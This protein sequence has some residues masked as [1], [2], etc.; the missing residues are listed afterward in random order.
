[1]NANG[2]PVTGPVNLKF[3]FAYTN[4]TASILCT[5]QI[6]GVVLT[7][8]VFHSKLE[9]DC[10][11]STFTSVLNLVPAGEALAIR[12]TDETHTKAYSFQALHAMPAAIMSTMSKQLVQMGAT[13]GQ[14]LAWDGSKWA[15][16]DESGT[17]DG[18]VTSVATG[19][20]LTGG[21]ITTT[22][23]ISIANGGVDTTQLANS[24]VTDAK[25]ATGI[26]R[27]KLAN[28]TANAVIVNSAAGVI[29]EVAQLALTQGGTGAITAAG[30]RTN[31]GLGTAAVADIGFGAGQ[32]M[33]G[34]SVPVCLAHEKLQMNVGPVYWSCAADNDSLDTTKVPLDGSVAMTGALN[35]NAHKILNVTSPTDPGDAANKAYVDAQ[36]GG[37]TS[38]QWL[39]NSG[40]IYYN[41]NNVGI[42]TNN[43]SHQFTTTGDAMVGSGGYP[44]FYLRDTNWWIGLLQSADTSWPDADSFVFNSPTGR[45]FVFQTG[46]AGKVEGTPRMLI[47]ATSGFVGIGTT[48]P[49]ERL[50][51]AGNAA[52]SGKLRL[53]SDNANFVELQAPAALAAGLTFKLPGVAGSAGNALVTDGAGNLSWAAVAT[54]ATSVGGDI[55]GTITNAQINAGAIA[56]AEVAAGAAI[57]Q[58]KI[59]NLTTDLAGKEPTITG[60][61]TDKYWRGDKTWQTLDT[62]VVPENTNLYFTEARV[63]GTDLAGFSATTGAVGAADTVLS[64]F[65]K[66]AGNLAATSAAQ[67]NYVEKDGDTMTGALILN[68]D[69]AVALGA[70]TKQYVDAQVSGTSYWTKTGT[71]VHYDGGNVGI[72]TS[73]PSSKLSVYGDGSYI[74][75]ETVTGLDNAIDGVFKYGYTGDLK[76]GGTGHTNRWHGLDATI[77]AGAGANNKL[78][79]KMFQGGNNNNAGAY[80]MTLQG[81][82][83]V[84]IGTTSPAA[85]LN[86]QGSGILVDNGTVD[87]PNIM[88][89]DATSAKT[90]NMDGYNGSFRIF[91]ETSLNGG[92][93]T[94]RFVMTS[95]GL[96][97]LNTASPGA[98]LDIA[99]TTSGLLIPRLTTAERNAIASPANGLQIF[100]T[101]T[102]EINF[103]HLPST[104]WKALGVAG[105]GVQS[106][107]ASTGLT[108]AGAITNTGT[109]AVDVGTGAGQI[110][111]LDGSAKIPAVDGSLVTNLN[112][113]NLSA[114]VPISK[115]GTGLNAAGTANTILGVNGAGTGLEYK[116]LV[117]NSPL[118]LTNAA[119]SATLDLGTVPVTKGGT[120]LS[121]LTGNMFYTSNA[122]GTAMQ[123]FSCP[124]SQIVTFNALGEPGCT[125]VSSMT[126]YGAD[127]GPVWSANTDGAFIK[128]RSTG[129]A[130]GASYLEIGTTDNSDESIIFT[131]TGAERLRIHTNGY[132][133]IGTTAPT[134]RLQVMDDTNPNM[135]VGT[136]VGDKGAMFLG[137]SNHGIMRGPS[138]ANIGFTPNG[139][140]VTVFTSNGVLHLANGPTGGSATPALTVLNDRRVG[141]GT[142]SPISV[143]T[144][145]GTNNPFAIQAGAGDHVYM[146]FYART[147]APTTRSGFIG[148]P[149]AG[150]NDLTIGNET[151]GDVVIPNG[152]VKAS[153]YLFTSDR[154][155]KKN[156]KTIHNA[157]DMVLGLRGV[158]FDWRKTGHHEL[159]FIAQEVEGIEPNLVVT[160]RSDGMKSV[161]YG[162]IVPVLVEAMKEQNREIASLKEENQKL[163][164][165][166]ELIK[167]HLKIK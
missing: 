41:A 100:N 67:A 143:L 80:V 83:N 61:T 163:K 107:T 128:L 125:T 108:P 32:V 77:T 68:A 71:A 102:S 17:G 148:Y 49:G 4:A 140:D 141:V 25:I 142:Q 8:G 78:L 122:L 139:N 11:P 59:A 84:G 86:V 89:R 69:P 36:V 55:N 135:I 145:S 110:L 53:K 93:G 97:G 119:G 98:A 46:A 157:L 167:K 24:S 16:S 44:A 95:T 96:A 164:E 73:N 28:G 113:V 161:K 150:S 43:P 5:Q 3:D 31:L 156:I 152:N 115:G 58:S 154:R 22:G 15:P 39:E 127:L 50:D 42:G 124:L 75:K 137:N 151:G 27:S 94:E 146:E 87:S 38:S 81:D 123:T 101:T 56:D 70:A 20:G 132:V 149:G 48:V 54:G 63:L 85:T 47:D 45:H 109:I 133:G 9:P 105:T 158:E 117:A 159:G 155:L 131:Q 65:E 64:A 111:Q 91:T 126:T 37:F 29:T 90:W 57:A 40:K 6:A 79:F 60:T 62:S 129:D 104:S 52:V 14:I 66:L 160:G 144:A 2:S 33:A 12:V 35:V 19:T 7:N 120:G 134:A 114:V 74:T 76:A 103:Y 166:I 130:V 51:I 82:G 34:N 18:T 116:A 147:A 23:T 138:G 88:F 10:T 72:G 21:P 99:S 92:G 1:M 121:S 136:S 106:I 153:A 30:A 118:A 165:E 13:P 162:N 112:P 26:T